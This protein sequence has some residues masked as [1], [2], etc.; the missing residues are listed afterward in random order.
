MGVALVGEEG[1]IG[2]GRKVDL[3]AFLALRIT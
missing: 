3:V 1:R 2:N